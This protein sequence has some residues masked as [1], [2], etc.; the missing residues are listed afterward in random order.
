M[1]ATILRIRES[2]SSS[3]DMHLPAFESDCPHKLNERATETNLTI[4]LLVASRLLA[5]TSHC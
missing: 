5:I 3:E 4:H 2:D 1:H